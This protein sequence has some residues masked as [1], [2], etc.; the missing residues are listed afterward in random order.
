[1][2]NIVYLKFRITETNGFV[3]DVMRWFHKDMAEDFAK[4]VIDGWAESSTIEY[5][6][7]TEP[8]HCTCEQE[9]EDD[10]PEE[11]TEDEYIEGLF[12]NLE[13]ESSKNDVWTNEY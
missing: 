10:L 13:G 7:V 3:R 2:G 12:F 8:P 9:H 6:G 11:L 5:L 1:M 4:S